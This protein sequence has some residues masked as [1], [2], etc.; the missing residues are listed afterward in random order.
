M[1]RLFKK[2][3]NKGF[4]L[5][6]LLAA[7]TIVGIILIAFIP[8]FPQVLSWTDK[9]KSNLVTDNIAGYFINKFKDDQELQIF[10]QK[11]NTI[12]NCDNPDT[13][14]VIYTDTESVQD[15]IYE[16]N[17]TVCQDDVIEEDLELS[18]YRIHL[19]VHPENDESSSIDTYF[20]LPG[21]GD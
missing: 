19:T 2:N 21:E 13:S 4:T 17:M 16:A 20:Y 6:E 1:Y 5:V 3:N 10:I 15:V 18:L 12:P 11:Q 8:V 9:N 7:L 14:D